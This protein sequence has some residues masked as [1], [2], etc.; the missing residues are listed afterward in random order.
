MHITLIALVWKCTPVFF[1]IYIFICIIFYIYVYEHGR[2]VVVVVSDNNDQRCA[3]TE[4]N[5]LSIV[6]GEINF[7]EHVIAPILFIS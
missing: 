4:T 2:E 7:N 5:H 3:M 1:Y 6:Q